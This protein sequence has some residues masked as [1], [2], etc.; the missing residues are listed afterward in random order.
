MGWSSASK[1]DNPAEYDRIVETAN[2]FTVDLS[3][4]DVN[5]SHTTGKYLSYFIDNTDIKQVGG[6]RFDL[7]ELD[8]YIEVDDVDHVQ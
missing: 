8:D 4:V 6:G 2:V 3:L 7:A 5:V 1:Q